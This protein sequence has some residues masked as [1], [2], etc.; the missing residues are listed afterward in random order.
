MAHPSAKEAKRSKYRLLGLVGHGQFGQ[1]Y[2]ATHRTT[3]HLVALKNLEHQRFP[4]HKFLRELRFL[5]SLQH[6]NIVTCE[7]LEHTS[8]GRH[9]VMDYCEGGTLR[10]LME[11]EGCLSLAQGLKLMVDVLTG[12]SHAHQRGII[13]CDIK[14]ENILLA[15]QADG[16]SARISD[17]GIARLSQELKMEGGATGSP[18]YMAPERFYGQ[19]SHSSDLYAVGIMLYEMLVGDRPFSGMPSDLMTA[20]LNQPVHIPEIVPAPLHPIITKSLQKLAA[21]RYKSADEMLAD[22][23][24]LLATDELIDSLEGVRLPLLPQGETIQIKFFRSQLWEKLTAP[25][26]AMMVIPEKP[27]ISPAWLYRAIKTASG[28]QLTFQPGEPT[29]NPKFPLL[30]N[31]AEPIRELVIRHQGC[32]AIASRSIYLVTHPHQVRGSDDQH[33]LLPRRLVQLDTDFQ[34]AIDPQGRWIATVLSYPQASQSFLTVWRSSNSS[35][36]ELD[37]IRL[38]KPM[39]CQAA[40]PSGVIALDSR[41]VAVI[42]TIAAHQG[43]QA[44]DSTLIEV[45]TRRGTEVG[46]WRLP[47]PTQMPVSSHR[48]YR[49]IAVDCTEPYSA[50]LIDVKPPRVLRVRLTLQPVLIAAMP[51]GYVL[52]DHQGQ[53]SLI[54]EDGLQVGQIAPPKDMMTDDATRVT[55]IAPLTVSQILLATWSEPEQAGVLHHINLQDFNLDFLF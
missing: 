17:F 23:Q 42:S 2:C 30:H 4:T 52:V 22:L 25:V 53:I 33:L 14:P 18:A 16:W 54:D 12:L 55:A 34:A 3:G 40:Q 15:V 19:Y 41:H 13:H 35:Q 29:T 39:T 27:D 9:L 43:T 1:V 10:S 11:R 49:L 44:S 26:L 5:L 24:R 47:I 46:S 7:A 38:T 36:W 8:T 21:R 31:L 48:P 32:F 37:R 51:W 6:R 20:H 50:L 45:F 28:C